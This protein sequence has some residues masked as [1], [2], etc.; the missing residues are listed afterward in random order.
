MH[1]EMG[2]CVNPALIF[3]IKDP[4]FYQPPLLNI[5]MDEKIKVETCLL[6]F[7]ELMLSTECKEN[8]LTLQISTEV[9]MVTR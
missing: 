4:S 1:E 8:V 2:E 7:F 5:L 6:K 9:S 3:F